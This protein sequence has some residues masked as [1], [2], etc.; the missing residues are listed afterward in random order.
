MKLKE[1]LGTHFLVILI[2]YLIVL[3]IAMIRMIFVDE[4]IGIVP[5]LGLPSN[6]NNIVFDF[7]IPNVGSMITVVLFSRLFTPLFLKGKRAIYRRHKDAFIDVEPQ[8]LSL[9]KFIKRGIFIFLLT[10][11]LLAFIVPLLEDYAYLFINEVTVSGYT[12]EGL[13]LNFVLPFFM[14]IVGLVLPIVIGLWSIGWMLEDSGL[15][16]YSLEKR[17]DQLFEIEPIHLRF[18]SYLKGY[19]GISAIVFLATLILYFSN[20]PGRL[21]D[22]VVLGFTPA[23]AI[24]NSIPA[25][26]VYGLSINKFNNLRKGLPEARKINEEELIP[27]RE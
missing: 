14:A 25:Y 27:I 7:I 4:Q 1:K 16:H 24:L 8:I 5:L 26:I 11:G 10:I 17:L 19:S 20:F 2:G 15:I 9:K 22:A 13:Q 12:A 23:I 3:P 21:S 18:N 6:I